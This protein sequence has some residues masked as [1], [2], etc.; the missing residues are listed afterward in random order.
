VLFSEREFFSPR[1]PDSSGGLGLLL[2][3]PGDVR[4]A[5]TSCRSRR[6]SSRFTSVAKPSGSLHPRVQ[7]AQPEHFGI[8]AIDCA[9]AR[10]KWM[11]ADFTGRIPAPPP[12]AEQPRRGFQEA[13]AALLQ[14][15][16]TDELRDLVIAIERTGADHQPVQRASVAAGSETRIVHPLAS[17]Q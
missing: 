12:T 6:R 13:I 14:A 5:T 17:K 3:Q 2:S 1:H 7:K 8:V 10:F 16:A 11:P 4:M 9:K 15:Q